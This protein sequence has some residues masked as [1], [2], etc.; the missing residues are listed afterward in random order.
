MTRWF[1]R[2]PL[3]IP[4]DPADLLGYDGILWSAGRRSLNEVKHG[5]MGKGGLQGTKISKISHVGKRKI[6]FQKYL[7]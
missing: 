4:K 1:Q 6:I 5:T 3:A 7:K 2:Y